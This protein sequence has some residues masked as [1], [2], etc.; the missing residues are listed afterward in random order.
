MVI[1]ECSETIEVFMGSSGIVNVPI[2]ID[3]EAVLGSMGTG[4]SH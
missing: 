2:I 1:S 3:F 4:V